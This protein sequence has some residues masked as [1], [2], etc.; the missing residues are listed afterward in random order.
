MRK[1][2]TPFTLIIALCLSFTVSTRSEALADPFITVKGI[3]SIEQGNMAKAE[4]LALND[5]FNKAL[6]I[7]A[8]QMV[9]TSQ[10]HALLDAFTGYLSIR[11]TRDITQYQIAKR[12]EE[13]NVLV[14]TINLQINDSHLR[15]WLD[16]KTL[17]VPTES[18]P[19]ILVAISYTQGQGEKPYAWWEKGGKPRYSPFEKALVER[20]QQWGENTFPDPPSHVTYNQENSL[21]DMAKISGA[22]LV[23]KGE[24]SYERNEQGLYTS[25][26]H[27]E[28]IDTLKGV[29]MGS[30]SI[31][32]V[33]D[34][35]PD[36]MN[37]YLAEKLIPPIRARITSKILA[38]NPVIT[39][40][41]ICIDGIRDYATYQAMIN[42]LGAMEDVLKI[43][44]SSI[45]GHA[46]CNSLTIRGSITHI[47]EALKEEQITDMNIEI[48]P[49]G[50][51]IKIIE[52]Q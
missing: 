49:E 10:I 44:P 12:A 30:W 3:G 36:D 11:G 40:T 16:S 42:A 25:T 31:K 48:K 23:L 43:T 13:N 4:Y 1:A 34:M 46:I 24:M 18:R 7:K 8:M 2:A 17:T 32:Q 35:G 15:Q 45:K 28:L 37:S 5:G 52:H 50:A 22:D 21:T 41:S 29:E 33:S 47:L 27:L 39:T 14:L 20:L 51:Y 9:P 38:L 19:R 26:L 6:L